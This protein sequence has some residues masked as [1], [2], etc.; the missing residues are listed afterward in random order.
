M[1]DIFLWTFHSVQF[2][3]ISLE[4]LV[5]KRIHTR[6]HSNPNPPEVL[7]S[8][9]KFFKK[10]KYAKETGTFL[11]EKYLSF[12][13]EEISF[14]DIQLDLK[15]VHNLFRSKSESNLSDMVLDETKLKHFTP[16]IV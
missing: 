7:T 10:M 11:L 9:G 15:F 16:S 6:I 1:A 4:I 3:A 5:Y 14:E 2:E 13:K 12:P 8:P